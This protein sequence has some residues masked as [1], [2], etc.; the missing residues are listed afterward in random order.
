MSFRDEERDVVVKR[1][2]AFLEKQGISKDA[3]APILCDHGETIVALEDVLQGEDMQ[4]IDIHAEVVA[5]Q[6]KGVALFLL[7]ADCIP[8]CFFDRV[9]NTIALAHVSRVTL[10]KGLPQKTIGFLRQRFNVNP[11]NLLV[12]LAPHIHKNS[13]VFPL[14]LETT[15]KALSPYMNKMNGQVSIDITTACIDAL[16]ESGVTKENVSVSPIDTAT[17]AEHFSYYAQKQK[18]EATTSRIATILMMK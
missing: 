13:Y 18:V 10:E 1:R 8:L 6:K 12:Y 11:S 3:Y 16:L 17:S 15:S 5:T 7:T 14:P 2:E 4:S 9:T